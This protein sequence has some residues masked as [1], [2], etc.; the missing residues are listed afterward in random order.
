MLMA[1]LVV[2]A[3]VVLLSPTAT[4]AD[5][6]TL[7]MPFTMLQYNIF[8]RP[9]VVSHDGQLERERTIPSALLQIP[10][11][12]LNVDV[13]TFAESDDSTEREKMFQQF[14]VRGYVYKTS[15]ALSF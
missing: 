5:A 6:L 11:S 12:L 10:D 7:T 1:P 4:Q 2:V 15:Y 8:G 13:A 3:V 14:A 9:Y